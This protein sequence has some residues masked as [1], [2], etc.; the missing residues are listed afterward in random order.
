MIFVNNKILWYSKST[1]KIIGDF[2]NVKDAIEN[3]RSI[4]KYIDKEVP[5]EY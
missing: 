4:R 3:R 2:M 1:K 5:Y